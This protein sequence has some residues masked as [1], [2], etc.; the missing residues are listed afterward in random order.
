MRYVRSRHSSSR[1][2]AIPL[3]SWSTWRPFTIS[4]IFGVGHGRCARWPRSRR[5]LYQSP[6]DSLRTSD[7]T[8][9][10]DWNQFRIED[11]TFVSALV[12][13][14]CSGY[15]TTCSPLRKRQELNS[16]SLR[17]SAGS[18]GVPACTRFSN[19]I[20]SHH[21]AGTTALQHLTLSRCCQNLTCCTHATLDRAM[22]CTEVA[23]ACSFAREE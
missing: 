21:R 18:A 7:N 13:G 22:N 8:E 3:R 20:A 16:G 10:S 23:Q 11:S 17:I 15:A 14:N 1:V 12:W 2:L 6:L 19:A 4:R 9:R 5:R